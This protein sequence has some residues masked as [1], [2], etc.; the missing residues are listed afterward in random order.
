MQST[1]ASVRA[2]IQI[3]GRVLVEL[4]G[5]VPEREVEQEPERAVHDPQQRVDE[6]RV[7]G[8]VLVVAG[9]EVLPE[10]LDRARGE[11][12]PL[13]DRVDERQPVVDVPQAQG[14]AGDEDQHEH[15]AVHARRTLVTAQPGGA[16]TGRWYGVFRC[17]RPPRRNAMRAIFCGPSSSPGARAGRRAPTRWSARSWSRTGACIGEGITQPPGEDHAEVMALEAAAGH[18][19]GATMYVSLEPCCHQGRTPP[20]TD[21][22][23]SAGIARVVIASDDPTPEGRRPRPGHPARRGH[24]GRLRGRRHRAPRRAC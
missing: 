18:T 9:V 21:A 19:A 22:I 15:E 17:P 16:E 12:G 13:V 3:C 2:A 14:E 1:A 23:L 8:G 11:V 6:V 4:V 5:D 20:C 7:R 10:H 24:Q